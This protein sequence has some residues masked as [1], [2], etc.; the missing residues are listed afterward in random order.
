MLYNYIM[1]KFIVFFI[2]LYLLPFIMA[3][4]YFNAHPTSDFIWQNSMSTVIGTLIM[5][6]GGVIIRNFIFIIFAL[7]SLFY[8]GK[9]MKILNNNFFI[10]IS[11]IFFDFFIYKI[12]VI[13]KVVWVGNIRTVED[14]GIYILLWT[15]SAAYFPIWVIYGLHNLFCFVKN[16]LN[17]AK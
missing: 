2:S 13:N 15:L 3:I 1:G 12:L 17:I 7:I 8:K 5:Y 10:L 9:F 14:A 16:K 6:F 4:V 11:L